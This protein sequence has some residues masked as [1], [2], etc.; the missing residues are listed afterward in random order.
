LSSEVED[1]LE[2]ALPEAYRID[3]AATKCQN[4]VEIAD[5]YLQIG[6]KSRCL[7]ILSEALRVADLIKQPEEKS[8]QL[9][10]AGRVFLESGDVIKSK[11]LFTRANLLARATETTAQQISSLSNLA[12]EYAEAKLNQ[13]AGKVLSELYELV[14]GSDSGVDI[15]CE[16]IN[17]AKLYFAI[18]NSD[19][20]LQTLEES[21]DIIRDLEDNWFKTER[22]IEAAEIY[23]EIGSKEDAVRLL[24]EARAVIGLIDERSQ[25]YFLL[26]MADGLVT[27]GQKTKAMEM[28]TDALVLVNK[29]EIAFSK[30]GDLITIAGMWVQLNDE[31]SAIN[32]LIQAEAAAESIEDIKDRVLRYLQTAR[33]YW[34]LEQAEK[35]LDIAAK[36]KD[37]IVKMED[38][39]SRMNLLGDLALLLVELNRHEPAVEIIS[40]MVRFITEERA[41]TSG[42][43]EIALDLASSGETSLALQLTGVIREPYIK[44]EALTGIARIL[45]E[46]AKQSDA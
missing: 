30:S 29:D 36:I 5:I 40:G 10:W 7:E 39:K 8:R 32:L 6:M 27:A 31:P 14:A 38:Q 28:L 25:P 44:A 33:L 13:E 43:G 17:I 26:K 42:L 20:A 22:L 24:S 1:L 12:V 34:E 45:A 16:L 11:E 21:L 35:S 37:L 15:A 2:Q 18:G 4:L 46:S 9:T 3:R 19:Q 41:K 23:F